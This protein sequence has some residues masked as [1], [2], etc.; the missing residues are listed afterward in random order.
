MLP[1]VCLNTSTLSLNALYID[2]NISLLSA[3]YLSPSGKL[4]GLIAEAGLTLSS[5]FVK[6]IAVGFNSRLQA[7]IDSGSSHC[8]VST[9]VCESNG[10]V[11]YAVDPVKLRYLDGS[12]SIIN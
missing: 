6:Q 2:L 4:S 9:N 12:S 1:E 5:S 7:L 10:F 8:F 3:D 11:P